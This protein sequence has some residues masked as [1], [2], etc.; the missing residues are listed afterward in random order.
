MEQASA[1]VCSSVARPDEDENAQ[2]EYPIFRAVPT[3]N[4]LAKLRQDDEH[5]ERQGDIELRSKGISPISQRVL[6]FE[7]KFANGEVEDS[8]QI[9]DESFDIDYPRHDEGETKEKINGTITN[10]E[11]MCIPISL[12][13]PPQKEFVTVTFCDKKNK[14]TTSM[15]SPPQKYK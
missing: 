12:M 2:R 1:A 8:E 4:G 14:P 7:I 5:R 13:P 10:P 11:L 15:I 9:G 6:V 3:K